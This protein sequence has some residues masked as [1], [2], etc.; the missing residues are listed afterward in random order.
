MNE[1]L[2]IASGYIKAYGERKRAE[3]ELRVAKSMLNYMARGGQGKA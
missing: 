1:A 2:V 3:A